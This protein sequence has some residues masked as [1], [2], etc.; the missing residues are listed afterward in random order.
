MFAPLFRFWESLT[1]ADNPA[2]GEA[3]PPGLQKPGEFYEPGKL[4]HSLWD[5]NGDVDRKPP[6]VPPRLGWM[7]RGESW[8]ARD[9]D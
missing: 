1:G 6:W 4:R 2:P 7:V 9:R 5:V 8:M 3:T